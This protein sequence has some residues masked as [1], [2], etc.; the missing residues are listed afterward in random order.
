MT[1]YTKD[2]GSSGEMMI[3]DL[4][5]TVEFWI[6][7]HNSST[8]NHQLPYGWTVN[9]SSGS[10]HVDYNAG[11]GWV[12]VKTFNVTKSQTVT[13]KIGDTGT[14]G[15]GGPTIFSHAVSGNAPPDPPHAPVIDSI[16]SLSFHVTF[17]DGSNNGAAIDQRRIGW[18]TSSAAPQ[19]FTNYSGGATISGL[20]A[21]TTYYVWAQT[22]NAN[23]WSG[24]SGRVSVT[25]QKVPAAP[26]RPSLFG[27]TPLQMTV[28]WAPGAIRSG[29]PPLT[30]AQVGWSL[31]DLANPTNVVD[32][33]SPYT[34]TGLQP[35]DTYFVRVRTKNKYGFS[36]WS[37]SSSTATIAGA[38]IKVGLVWKFA[39]AYVR[40]GGVWKKAQPWQNNAGTWKET[41]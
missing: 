29:D 26:G 11:A 23:G 35:G 14:S 37:V 9:G 33:T 6:N 17:T 20:A 13:F 40:V 24:L 10:S 3:R 38:R 7:S 16:T 8:F 25:T 2:T 28:S 19:F 4:A 27:I 36:P 1:D 34:I 39:T 22:H 15:F 31:T 18:G 12:K 21:G 32:A 30:G 41:I 5:S